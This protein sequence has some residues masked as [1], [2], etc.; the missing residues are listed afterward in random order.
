MFGFLRRLFGRS[1]S[2]A[3]EQAL[4]C[5]R[6]ADH[7]GALLALDQAIQ[8]D[9]AHSDSLYLRGL[10]HEITGDY[11]KALADLKAAHKLKPTSVDC[12]EV[13]WNRKPVSVLRTGPRLARSGR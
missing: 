11:K 9:A 2:T 10:V 1:A 5:E 4:V 12:L 6:E 7:D 8:L 3:Y 13:D